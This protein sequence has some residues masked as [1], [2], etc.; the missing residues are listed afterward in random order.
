MN[1]QIRYLSKS[2]NTKKVAD[3]IAKEVGVAAETIE[4]AVPGDTDILFLG[5]AMYWAGVDNKL[6]KFILG[7]DCSVKKVAIFSTTAVV[8]SAYPEIKKLLMAKN[9]FVYD[10]EFHCKGEFLKLHKGRPNADD[11]ELA[12]QFARD[13]TSINNFR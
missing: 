13:I 12:K 7:L 5:G 3:A 8:K 2:G 4:N 1:I 6:K 10:N 11:L 9:I